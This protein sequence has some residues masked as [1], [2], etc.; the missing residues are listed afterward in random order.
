MSLVTGTLDAV[1]RAAYTS[2]YTSGDWSGEAEPSHWCAAQFAEEWAR[3]VSLYRAVVA[4][5]ATDPPTRLSEHA[6]TVA[7]TQLSEA[8][9]WYRL[10]PVAEVLALTDPVE[11]TDALA[12]RDL[13]VEQDPRRE[14]RFFGAR[15]GGTAEEAARERFERFERFGREVDRITAERARIEDSFV[16]TVRP[17]AGAQAAALDTL[18]VDVLGPAAFTIS[19]D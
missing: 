8:L 13:L 16:Q 2:R 14:S 12:P 5:R 7:T 9:V 19:D 11:I 4:L 3:L 18:A 10:K 15:V 6:V 17:F 1:L